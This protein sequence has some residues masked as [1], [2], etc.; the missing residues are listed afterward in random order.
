VGLAIAKHLIER[1][2][3]KIDVGTNSGAVFR[4]NLPIS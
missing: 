1:H 2:G 3:G 4:A